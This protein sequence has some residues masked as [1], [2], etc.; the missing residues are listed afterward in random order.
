MVTCTPPLAARLTR[1]LKTSRTKPGKSVG[2]ALRAITRFVAFLPFTRSGVTPVSVVREAEGGL[3]CDLKHLWV[4]CYT[5]LA[6]HLARLP[7]L[8]APARV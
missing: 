3:R 6:M 2:F 1:D 5:H 7:P 8:P 4:R